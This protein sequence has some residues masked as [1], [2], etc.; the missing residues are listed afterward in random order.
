MASIK[1]N[2]Y[3][4]DAADGVYVVRL[5]DTPIISKL[6]PGSIEITKEEFD[7]LNVPSPAE[8]SVA[9]VAAKNIADTVAAKA[10]SKLAALE[11]MSPLEVQTWV[12]SHVTNLAQAQDAI[13]TLAIAISVLIRRL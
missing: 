4:K 2:F 9:E 8:I 12:A 5:Q 7:V 3:F 6:P 13:T 11:N 1:H 10:Y